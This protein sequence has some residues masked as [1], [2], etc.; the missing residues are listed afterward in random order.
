MDNNIATLLSNIIAVDQ[1][2]RKN[3][4]F[5]ESLI[6]KFDGVS[7]DIIKALVEKYGLPTPENVGVEAARYFIVLLI[8]TVDMKYAIKL[9]N[10][11]EFKKATYSK[12]VLAILRDRILLFQGKKQCFGMVVKA[13][14]DESG[15]FVAKPLP[16]RDEKNVDKRR[17]EFG[18]SPLV[19]YIKMSEEGFNNIPKNK[20]KS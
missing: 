13:K 4:V 12:T 2:L 3:K 18:L 15:R 8:H 17:K 9:S 19:D 10:T 11:P 1:W 5:S 20:P 7:T 14:K 6:Q 16:I